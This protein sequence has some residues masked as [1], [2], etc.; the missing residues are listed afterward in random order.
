M[1]LISNIYEIASRINAS[2]Y[3][4]CELLS[5]WFPDMQ[6]VFLMHIPEIILYPIILENAAWADQTNWQILIPGYALTG[7][8][9]PSWKLALVFPQGFCILFSPLQNS[10]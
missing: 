8:H 9:S 4:L 2:L 3:L 10:K 1:Y 6:Q 5:T 7:I